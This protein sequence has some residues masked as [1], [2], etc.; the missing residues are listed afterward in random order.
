METALVTTQTRWAVDPEHCEI[1][2]KIRHLMI[3]YLIAFHQ[4]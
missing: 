2:F 3:A 1:A 4:I